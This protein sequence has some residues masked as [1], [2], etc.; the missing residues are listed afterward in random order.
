MCLFHTFSNPGPV[1]STGDTIQRSFSSISPN[2]WA[3]EMA[4][5][6]NVDEDTEE[7][8]MQDLG[9]KAEE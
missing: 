2:P 6:E 9:P 5:L 1:L 7:L 4:E 3:A 8:L